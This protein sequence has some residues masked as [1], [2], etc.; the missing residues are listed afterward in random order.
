MPFDL[1]N[2]LSFVGVSISEIINNDNSDEFFQ[3]YSTILLINTLDRRCKNGTIVCSEKKKI[4]I[5]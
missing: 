1:I 2:V 3:K 5:V 4:K